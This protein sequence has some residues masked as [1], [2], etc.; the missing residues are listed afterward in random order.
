MRGGET[1]NL[2]VGGSIPAH[3]KILFFRGLFSFFFISF[4]LCLFRPDLCRFLACVGEV[5]LRL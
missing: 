2:Q 5:H 3:D 1:R 4:F